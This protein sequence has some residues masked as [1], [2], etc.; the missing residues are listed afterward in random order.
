MNVRGWEWGYQT[1]TSSNKVGEESKFWSFCDDAIIECPLRSMYKLLSSY[2][3]IGVFRTLSNNE[4]GA[5][6]KK[7]NTWVQA[8]DQKLFRAAEIS[9]KAPHGNIL[10]FFLLDIIKTTFWIQSLKMDTIR[11]IISKS[12]TLVWILKEQE[13]IP[14]LPLP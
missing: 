8:H 2:R 12:R 7:K 3:D 5:F 13:R 1:W 10:E 6:C 11:D 9:W 4:D 14:P